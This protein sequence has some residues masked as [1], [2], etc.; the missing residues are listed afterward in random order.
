MLNVY[1]YLLTL[2][3]LRDDV[4]LTRVRVGVV[5]GGG[6]LNVYVYLLPLTMLR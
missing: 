5:W 2:A 4:T 6:M 3:M 1:V